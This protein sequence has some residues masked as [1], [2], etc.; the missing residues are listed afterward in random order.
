MYTEVVTSLTETFMS[1]YANSN[2]MQLTHSYMKASI[3]QLK[4]S[5][6]LVYFPVWNFGTI[7]LQFNHVG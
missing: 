2:A 3:Y 7:E 5:F 6:R 4:C 1:K